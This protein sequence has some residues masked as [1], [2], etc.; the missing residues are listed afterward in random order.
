MCNLYSITRN[1]E[2]MRRLFRIMRDTTG[3]LP[4]LPAATEP[5]QCV[6]DECAQSEIAL[7]A[8]LAQTGLALP[9]SGNIILRMDRQPAE[10]DAL[11]WIGP[12][13]ATTVLN[14]LK[15]FIRCVFRSRWGQNNFSPLF[16]W[17]DEVSCTTSWG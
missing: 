9:C 3:N 4:A 6:G 8:R 7:L 11:V 1:Q 10:G 14:V 15:M 5:R 17:R 13:S 2:A 12:V 16:L